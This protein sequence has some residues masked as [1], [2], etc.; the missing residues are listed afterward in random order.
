MIGAAVQRA[1]RE[2]EPRTDRRAVLQI[3]GRRFSQ[4]RGS[5]F[6]QGARLVC[7]NGEGDIYST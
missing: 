1:I 5:A 3:S 7:G 4:S 2:E 6:G